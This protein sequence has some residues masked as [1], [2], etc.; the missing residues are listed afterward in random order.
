M[1][2]PATTE[3]QSYT[4]DPGQLRE[5]AGRLASHAGQL[6]SLGTALP[7]EM[8]AQSLGA[9]A[10]FI[11][12]GLGNAMTET[13][14]AFQRASSTL[15][16]VAGGMR[17]AADQYQRADDDHAATLTGIGSSLEEIA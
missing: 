17:R 1:T 13:A 15:D 12:A 2:G 6:A 3:S 11:T 8:G 16:A 14:D 9:F 4:V 10:Q 7:G 5:H